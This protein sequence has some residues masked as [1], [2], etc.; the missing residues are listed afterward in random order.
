MATY[1]FFGYKQICYDFKTTT[2]SS[3]YGCSGNLL[4]LF[5]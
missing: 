2:N 3:S 1:L 4:I 5:R